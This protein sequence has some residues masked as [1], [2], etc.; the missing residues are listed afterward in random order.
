MKPTLEQSC[1]C[2]Q[3]QKL[4]TDIKPGWFLP[5]EIAPLAKFL[6]LSIEETFNKHLLVDYWVGW[7][8]K[9]EEKKEGHSEDVNVLAPNTI[10]FEP[11]RVAM[12]THLGDTCTFYKEGKC[13]IHEVKPYECGISKACEDDMPK[14]HKE[15]AKKWI[16]H[17]DFIKNLLPI[18]EQD[19]L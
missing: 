4:C 10:S 6:N 12:F 16:E 18:E 17:Q 11:G 14:V 7:E 13:S 8:Y 19:A 5:E 15:V 3:C 2:P 9:D 1:S